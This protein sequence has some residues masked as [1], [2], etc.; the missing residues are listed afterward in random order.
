M[1]HLLLILICKTRCTNISDIHIPDFT[2][3]NSY[4]LN[5]KHKKNKT[6][7]KQPFCLVFI[8]VCIVYLLAKRSA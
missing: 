1:K 2:K 4:N 6:K 3:R 8:I 5:N 7:G